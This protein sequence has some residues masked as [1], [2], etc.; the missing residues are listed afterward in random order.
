MFDAAATAILHAVL[1]EVCE[2]CLAS[3]IGAARARPLQ[4][5]GSCPRQARYRP[6]IFGRSVVTPYRTR[7]RCALI[8]R[9]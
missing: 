5:S 1:D 3:R 7:Q 4:D 2:K 8:E 6:T 9:C